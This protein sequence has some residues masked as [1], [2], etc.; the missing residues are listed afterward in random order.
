MIFLLILGP[1]KS[2]ISHVVDVVVDKERARARDAGRVRLRKLLRSR[3]HVRLA[4]GQT[5]VGYRK[6]AHATSGVCL[7]ERQSKPAFMQ[8]SRGFPEGGTRYGRPAVV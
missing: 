3:G 5:N 4:K 1:K 6:N 2:K 7:G 8:W